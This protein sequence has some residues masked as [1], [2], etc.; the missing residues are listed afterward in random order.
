METGYEVRL[1][2]SAGRR[3]PFG[4]PV[5]TTVA[6]SLSG[7]LIPTANTRPGD[8]WSWQNEPGPGVGEPPEDE[9]VRRPI[10]R[11]EKVRRVRVPEEGTAAPVPSG[12]D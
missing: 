5:P 2:R 4:A 12:P 3:R 7:L 1:P 11:M 10:A 6:P 8:P 9:I